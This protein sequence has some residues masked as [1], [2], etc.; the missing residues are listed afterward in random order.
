MK[1]KILFV[2]II[3]LGFAASAA[4]QSAR[5]QHRRIAQ[6]VRS[7]ELTRAETRNLVRDQREIRRDVRA[8]KSDGVVTP[9]ERREIRQDR[10]QA[11]REICRK[12]HNRRDRN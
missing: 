4:A 10:R 8:A 11:S 12:K 3:M 9:G 1:T 5:N 7:G 2:A 6:G